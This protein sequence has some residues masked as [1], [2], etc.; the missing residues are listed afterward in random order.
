MATFQITYKK[1]FHPSLVRADLVALARQA[2]GE[3]THDGAHGG[4]V[5]CPTSHEWIIDQ[6]VSSGMVQ[7]HNRK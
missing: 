7:S 5:T 6:A 1:R 4:T 3:F 2:S